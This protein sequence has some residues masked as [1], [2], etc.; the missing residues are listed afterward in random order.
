MAWKS[1]AIKL[2]TECELTFDSCALQ[3]LPWCK[4]MKPERKFDRT[5]VAVSSF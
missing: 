1:V 3:L 4:L 2:A 5:T